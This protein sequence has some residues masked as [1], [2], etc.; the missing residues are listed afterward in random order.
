MVVPIWEFETFRKEMQL[1]GFRAISVDL[2]RAQD[3]FFRTGCSGALAL[4]VFMS[5][6]RCGRNAGTCYTVCSL[7]LNVECDTFRASQKTGDTLVAGFQP[8]SSMQHVCCSQIDPC[9]E[10]ET[11]S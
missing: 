6:N 3:N 5:M 8:L 1:T 11:L 2:K 4:A 7:V 10:E 9:C